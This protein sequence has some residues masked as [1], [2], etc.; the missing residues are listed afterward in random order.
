MNLIDVHCH[1]NHKEYKDDLD[2]VIKR[3]K[4]AGL[5][6]IIVSGTNTAANKQVLELAKR[7][8]I[9][10]I[11]LGIHPI[12]ALGLSEGETGIPKQLEPINLDE[13]FKF[14]E[15][16]IKEN[17]DLIV[18]I[19]E[20]GLDFHWDKEHH[21][22]QKEVFRKIIQFCIKVNKPIIVH[23]WDAEEECIDIL[24]EELKIGEES[25]EKLNVGK[26]SENNESK[27][28]IPVI[29]HCFGGRKSLI[30]RAKAL[31]FYF[32]VPPSILRIGNFQ[33]LVKKVDLKQ[34]LTETDAP[35][36]SPYKGERSEPAFVM[37]T[38]K[39]IAHIKK[40][41]EEEVAEQIWQ[42]YQDVFIEQ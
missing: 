1:L 39:K 37:E 13:E 12:D 8:P 10:K 14:I 27:S 26:E 19:G 17:K 21:Q 30:S 20:V 22:E 18:G 29:L 41:T 3:A 31:G 24:E 16:K 35:W 33:T 28:K 36:Q 40:L 6:A 25:K 15:E 38:I 42:N 23:T 9:I 4:K 7:D 11:S 5:K 32:T 2:E 34:I